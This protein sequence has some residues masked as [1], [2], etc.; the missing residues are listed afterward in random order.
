MKE[1]IFFM[2][3][4]VFALFATCCKAQ[5]KISKVTALTEVFGNGQKVTAAIVEYDKAIK[6]SGLSA[7]DF[8][9]E[10]RTI[11]KVYASDSVEKSSAGKDGKYVIIELSPDDELA[12]TFYQ[13]AG[14]TTRR[15]ARVNIKQLS[16]IKSVD[17]MSAPLTVEYIESTRQINLVV[18]DFVQRTYTYNPTGDT[19]QYN[20]FIPKD[21][22]PAISYP[23]VLFMHDAGAT[24]SNVLTTLIQGNGAIVWATPGEQAKHPCFVLAPQYEVQIVNDNS[25]ATVHLDMTIDLIKDLMKEYSIDGNRLYTTGQ[26]GG[27]MMSI[28]MDIKYPDFFAAS[29]LVAGQWDA[30]LVAPMANDNLWIT[31]SEGDTKAFPGMNAITTAL[32]KAGARVSR[33][34]WDGQSTPQEFEREVNQM[35]AEDSNVKYVAFKLGTTIPEALRSQTRGGSE[36]RG[37]WQVAYNIEGIR[38]WLFEQTKK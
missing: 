13:D 30:S 20:L 17:G 31:V 28:A 19:L 8:S 24:S 26:S 9:V 12:P 33:A 5:N 3:I 18:D 36:H 22:D 23:L 10:G 34:V 21:Y 4:L 1:K 6:N 25:E 32:E 2:A 35:L 15:D 29:Y 16:A 38:E 7:N 37:T 27:C 14:K 11:T